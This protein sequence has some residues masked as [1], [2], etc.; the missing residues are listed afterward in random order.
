MILN[1]VLDKNDED[2]LDRSCVKGTAT[3]SQEGEKYSTSNKKKKGYLNSTYLACELRS[4][5]PY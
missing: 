3:Q 5:T 4:K 1:V 2:Q